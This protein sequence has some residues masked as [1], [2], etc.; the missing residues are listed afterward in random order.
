MSENTTI[1]CP[2]CNSSI[3]IEDALYMQLKSKFDLNM[4]AERAKYKKA[5][6]DLSLQQH[7]TVQTI[8]YKIYNIAG[9]VIQHT[10]KTTL[11]VNSEFVNLI[12]Q[13]RQKSY[14][15]CLQ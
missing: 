14:Q 12:N 4:Q 2:H 15:I 8:R 13:I 9:K 7:H 1:K 5:I 11:K 3:N 10:R 6:E